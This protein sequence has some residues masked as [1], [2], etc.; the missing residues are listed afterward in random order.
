MRWISG[1]LTVMFLMCMGEAWG[2]D[3]TVS[4]IPVQFGQYITI[5]A[6]PV[7]AIGSVNVSCGSSTPFTVKLDAGENSYSSFHPRK[8]RSASSGATL[9]Y[10]LYLDSA[11][12]KVWGDGTNN[13]F[14]RSGIGIGTSQQFSIYGRIPGSQNVSVGSFNDSVTVILE[15]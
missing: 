4:A 2:Q 13:T 12:T 9:N 10:N 8:L 3:C 7:D 15:W 1:V 14:I 6:S 5:E 11:R